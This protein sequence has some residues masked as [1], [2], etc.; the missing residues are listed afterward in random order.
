MRL[1]LLSTLLLVGCP[2]KEMKSLDEIE[3]EKR[4]Q[5]LFEEEDEIFDDLPEAGEEDEKRDSET[6]D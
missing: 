5:E 3:R 6:A 1:L 2:K 4:L